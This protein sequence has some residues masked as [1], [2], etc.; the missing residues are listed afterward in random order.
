MVIYSPGPNFSV[1]ANLYMMKMAIEK[2]Q[3]DELVGATISELH[4]AVNRIRYTTKP[5]V[6]ATQGR[7]LGGGAE[8]LLASPAIVA[9]T[10]SYIGLRSEERRVGKESRCWR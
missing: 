9:A 4:E 8:I 5:I 1:G 3:V 6:T 7:A 2:D 10:E